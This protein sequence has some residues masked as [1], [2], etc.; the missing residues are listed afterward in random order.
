MAARTS[1][2]LGLAS[3]S[4]EEAKSGDLRVSL[5]IWCLMRKTKTTRNQS[6]ERI[7]RIATEGLPYLL[8]AFLV[9]SCLVLTPLK[10]YPSPSSRPPFLSKVARWRPTRGSRRC[11]GRGDPTWWST[12]EHHGGWTEPAGPGTRFSR[13]VRRV[14]LGGDASEEVSAD[15]GRGWGFLETVLR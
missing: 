12:A 4:I 5:I 1:T 7:A 14:G 6:F 13:G 3:V 8:L 10:S 11:L 2:S 9:C 15:V